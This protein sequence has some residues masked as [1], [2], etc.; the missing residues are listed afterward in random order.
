MVAKAV[1]VPSPGARKNVE[2]QK[3]VVEN[4]PRPFKRRRDDNGETNNQDESDDADDEAEE[5]K[6]KR[7]KKSA[8]VK[9]KSKNPKSKAKGKRK[10]QAKA[11]QDG[12]DEK[13]I[14][15]FRLNGL[16]LVGST[17]IYL[18]GPKVS[19]TSYLNQIDYHKKL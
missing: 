6:R 18:R 16:F 7:R 8:K 5:R 3:Q 10:A 17:D 13:G 15:V 14:V 11:K 19:K 9:A 12:L 4:V 1:V 2:K